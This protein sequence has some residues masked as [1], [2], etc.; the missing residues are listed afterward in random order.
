MPLR[1]LTETLD[2][3]YTT[4][5]QNMKDDVADQIFDGSPFWFWM[6]QNDRL[7]SV[8]GGRF[9][10]EPVR[11]AKSDAVQFVSKGDSVALNDREFLAIAND[12]WRYMVDVIVRFGIDDQQNRGKNQILSLMQAKLD[13]SRDSMVDTLESTLFGTQAGK[14]FNGLQN[15]VANDPTTGTL[16]GINRATFTWFRNQF[17]D[18]SVG[19]TYDSDPIEVLNK[20]VNDCS[21]NL[22]QDTPDIIVSSQ[23]P[24]EQYW[25]Q[26]V[27]GQLRIVN[28]TLGDAGFRN[29]EFRGIPWVWSPQSNNTDGQQR[30]YLLNTRF[31]KFKYD[32][33]MMFDMTEWKPIPS[34]IND[35]AAQ[36][37]LAG[38]LFTSRPRVHGVIFSI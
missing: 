32:P 28:K 22:R 23:R 33:M 15:L 20:M 3:L 7:E 21:K 2:N 35:R 9:L 27:D 14:S 4:T 30:V 17:K 18:G 5:W 11:Y 1:S 37:I 34:Q 12:D 8:E 24:F 29:I 16:H 13:N 10:T 25:L 31:L 38:N 19:P 6:R 36:V 26:M